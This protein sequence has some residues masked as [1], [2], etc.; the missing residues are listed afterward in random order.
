VAPPCGSAV[1]SPHA[2]PQRG[3][4]TAAVHRLGRAHP[5][6]GAG[7]GG[8]LPT[9]AAHIPPPF[10]SLL[11]GPVLLG[12]A[13]GRGQRSARRLLVVPAGDPWPNR[14]PWPYAGEV[15]EWERPPRRPWERRKPG[16]SP[17][18]TRRRKNACEVVSRRAK[19]SGTAWEWMAAYSGNAARSS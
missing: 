8:H 5:G 2:A 15:Q 11:T 12:P 7:V 6:E 4:A 14:A 17:A 13:R 10:A 9:G 16:C 18:A 3:G 1:G 19:T